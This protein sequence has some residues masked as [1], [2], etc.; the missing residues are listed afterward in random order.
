MISN[1]VTAATIAAAVVTILVW[2]AS[3]ADVHIPSEVQGAA[4]VV[5]VAAAGYVVTDP[6]RIPDA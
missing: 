5:L 6:A 3:L 1:K 4:T 2:L